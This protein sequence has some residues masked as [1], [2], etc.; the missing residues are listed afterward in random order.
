MP[1][2]SERERT[3]AYRSRLRAMGLRPVQVWV[4]DVTR[5]GFAK[6]LRRQVGLVRSQP[7]EDEALDF[8]EAAQDTR[9]WE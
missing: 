7:E 9:G 6:E 4:P 5:P 8:I 2:K 1:Q 3:E